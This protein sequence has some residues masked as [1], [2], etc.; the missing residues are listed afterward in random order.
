MRAFLAVLL[1]IPALSY[2]EDPVVTAPAAPVSATVPVAPADPMAAAEALWAQRVDP[3]QLEKA[4]TAYEAILATDPGNTKV[5]ERLIRGWYFY[6]DAHTDDAPTKIARWQKA[7]DYGNTCLALN[8]T[9]KERLAGG[10]REKDAIVVATADQVPCLYW[11]STALGKWAKAQSLSVTLKNL[12]TVKAYMSKVEEYDP[13]YFNYGPARYWGVY[14]AALPSFAGNDPVKSGQYFQ[15]SI[16]GAPDYLPTRGLRAEYLA[17]LKQDAKLFEDDL[18]AVIAADPTRLPDCTPENI[19]EQAKAKKLLA[20]ESELF[21]AAPAD[22][23]K[24]KKKAN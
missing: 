16:D 6:G 10:E 19:M 13:T 3:A 14:Y 9:Y 17:V 4:L 2:A 23:G 18:N 12:P 24:K 5:L 1:L 7:V 21:F 20:K 8:P 15:A 11:T 22:D